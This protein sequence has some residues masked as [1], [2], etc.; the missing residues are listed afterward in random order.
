VTAGGA[1]RAAGVWLALALVLVGAGGCR[2]GAA[3]TAPPLSTVVLSEVGPGYAVSSEGPLTAGSLASSS[4]DPSSAA[5]ALEALGTSVSTYQRVWATAGGLNEV[6]D[7]MVAFP[8]PAAAGI[9]LSSMEHALDSGEIVSSG[10][11]PSL[12]GAHRTTYFAAI[13]APGVGQAITMR[14]GVYV[15]LLSFF[16]ASAGN[17]QPITPADAVTIATAQRVAME[18]ATAKSPGVAAPAPSSHS[19]AGT[20][21][22]VGVLVL[23]AALAWVGVRRRRRRRP[24]R[25]TTV[26]SPG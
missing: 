17:A 21:L 11:L 24:P 4:P 1:V 15:N 13:T 6:Q 2:A 9:F 26:R 25:P 3:T 5:G 23:L 19:A 12:P 10:P 18:A 8:S 20:L 7:L 14:V 16:S 22:L